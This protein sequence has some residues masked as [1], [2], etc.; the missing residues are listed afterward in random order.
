MATKKSVSKKAT[1]AT[2]TVKKAVNKKTTKFDFSDSIKAIK[3]TAKTLNTQLKDVAVEVTDDLKVNG[4]QLK[5]VAVEAVNPLMD[6]YEKASTKV[7]EMTTDMTDR[8]M[9]MT[10][11]VTDRV[12]ETVNVEN[13]TKAT[14]DVNAYTLKTADELVD[15]AIKN[16]EKW[17]GVANKA[18][19][20][21]LKLAAKQQDIMFDNLETIKGQL[22]NTA[23]RLKKLI[24][25]N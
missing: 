20:G 5:E 15:G 25:N 24:S 2:K 9:D 7:V 8:V 19:K 3:G 18:V 16:G 1:K 22:T 12:T 17:Q 21:S 4:K 14:K 13:I 10:G 23:T 6:V 11:K